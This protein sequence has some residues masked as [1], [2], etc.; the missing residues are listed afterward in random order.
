MRNVIEVP[1]DK[2]I[3]EVENQLKSGGLFLSSKGEKANTMVIGWGGIT[4]F[5]GEPIFLVPVRKSRYTHGLIEQSGEFTVSV[6][7]NRDLKKALAFCGSRSGRDFDKFKECNLTP[8]PGIKVDAPIIGECTLHYECKV[9]YKQDM[10]PE[11]L[12]AQ[13]TQ[14]CYPSSDYHTF[15][16]GKI[17]ACYTT[18]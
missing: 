16:F 13:L 5:W 10:V 3:L 8:I 11:N 12:D 2:Y 7:L 9:I 4:I 1:Y 15:Y 6:P 18:E 14:K 17:V